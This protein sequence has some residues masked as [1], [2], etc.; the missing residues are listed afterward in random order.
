MPPRTEDFLGERLFGDLEFKPFWRKYLS[1]VDKATEDLR[2]ALKTPSRRF[3]LH[4]YWFLPND[5]ILLRDKQGLLNLFET[6]ERTAYRAHISAWAEFARGTWMDA[7]PTQA[8][9]YPVRDKQGVR[10]T[11]REIREVADGLKDVS[12]GFVPKGLVTTFVG[13]WWSVPIP[14]LPGCV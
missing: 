4:E 12:G 11:D 9:V 14:R 7:I 8:G 6:A 3:K 2:A 5:L 1:E 13:S 10:R